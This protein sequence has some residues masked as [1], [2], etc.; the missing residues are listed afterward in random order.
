MIKEV[1]AFLSTN[2]KTN[3]LREVYFILNIKLLREGW[4]GE[5][6]LV[7]SYYMEKVLSRLDIVIAYVL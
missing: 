6:T 1:K 2:F 3:E 4:N 7:Q 5:V